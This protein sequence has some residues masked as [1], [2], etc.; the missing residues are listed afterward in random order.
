MGVRS[1][2]P[3]G[4]SS[5]TKHRT[6][7]NVSL[8]P[9]H[10]TPAVVGPRARSRR[11]RGDLHRPQA[12]GRLARLRR[13]AA[14]RVSALHAPG[15]RSVGTLP[16]HHGTARATAR[17]SRRMARSCRDLRSTG[18]AREPEACTR[19]LSDGRSHRP[20]SRRRGPR[21]RIRVSTHGGTVGPAR[22]CP[23]GIRATARN[24]QRVESLFREGCAAWLA[25]VDDQTPR[26]ERSV[27][28]DER[29]AP[30]TPAPAS[31]A[32]EGRR[33]AQTSARAA[34]E[35]GPRRLVPLDPQR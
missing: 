22:S 21:G 29:R 27:E 4:S 24:A 18:V 11:R 2:P 34:R 3:S 10:A 26:R 8:G 28:G 12:G 25:S 19:A 35:H 32:R 7:W 20:G 5:P 33:V 14:R 17:A 13:G 9:R 30:P 6:S 1:A 31:S 16:G 23:H 15:L